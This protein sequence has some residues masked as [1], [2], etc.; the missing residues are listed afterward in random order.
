MHGKQVTDAIASRRFHREIRFHLVT[1]GKD[2]I[3]A[4]RRLPTAGIIDKEGT[5]S[6]HVVCPETAGDGEHVAGHSIINVRDFIDYG[7]AQEQLDGAE[8]FDIKRIRQN[9]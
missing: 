9:I 3:R 1:D 4:H 5:G 2:M 6:V 7:P 8:D